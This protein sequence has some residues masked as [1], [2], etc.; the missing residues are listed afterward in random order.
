M[1]FLLTP[2]LIL[3]VF[4]KGHS[5]GNSNVLIAEVQKFLLCGEYEQ[6][7]ELSGINAV[8]LQISTVIRRLIANYAVILQPFCIV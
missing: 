4:L 1:Y 5:L 8:G 7:F 2:L 6:L 3:W